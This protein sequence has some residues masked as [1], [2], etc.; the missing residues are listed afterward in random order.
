M[1]ITKYGRDEIIRAYLYKGVAFLQ[2]S[3]LLKKANGNRYVVLH[4]LMQGLEIILKSCLLAHDYKKY[5][6]ILPYKPY[7]HNVVRCVDE[8]LKITGKKPLPSKAGL[9]LSALSNLYANTVLRYGGL[10]DLFIDPKSIE[11]DEIM[12]LMIPLIKFAKV[13]TGAA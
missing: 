5:K 12:R 6:P 13:K 4:N 8:I 9:Q 3:V 1:P 10:N 2:A 11:Y 7:G